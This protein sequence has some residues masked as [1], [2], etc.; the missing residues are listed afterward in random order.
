MTP[1]ASLSQPWLTGPS[2]HLDLVQLQLEAQHLG[3]DAGDGAEDEDPCAVVEEGV[4][5]QA[6]DLEGRLQLLEEVAG[7]LEDVVRQE[8]L[9]LLVWLQLHLE[10]EVDLLGEEDGEVPVLVVDLAGQGHEADEEEA[11]GHAPGEDLGRGKTRPGGRRQI[12]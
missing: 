8:E 12:T 3:E 4:G 11:H 6:V 5:G 10:V 2:L 9:L 7:E 1:P